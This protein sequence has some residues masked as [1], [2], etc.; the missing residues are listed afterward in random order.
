LTL[1]DARTRLIARLRTRK[2]RAEEG[3]VLVEGP[4]AVATALHAGAQFRFGVGVA[5]ALDGMRGALGTANRTDWIEVDAK[6]FSQLADTE[7]PQGVLAV[8]EEPRSTLPGPGEG[9]QERRFLILDGVQDPGNAGTLVRSAAAFGLD[10]ILALDGTVDLWNA[11]AVRAAAGEVFRIPVQRMTG[12]DFLDWWPRQGLPLWAAD[13]RG[14]DVRRVENPSARVGQ[15][16]WGLALGNEGAGLRPTVL[17]RADRILALPL[18]RPVESLNVAVAGS[19]LLWELGPGRE[20]PPV[21]VE[22]P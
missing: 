9:L 10:G 22:V 12:S 6:A 4:R 17:E 3:L 14:E 13:A 15:G 8:V 19:I 20:T 21:N 2:G 5:S 1:S 16:G 18:V 11:K 7:A